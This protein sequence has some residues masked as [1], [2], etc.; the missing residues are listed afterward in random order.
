MKTP[1]QELIDEL[2]PFANEEDAI[3]KSMGG[4][5]ALAKILKKK[6]KVHIHTAFMMGKADAITN[7]YQN[8]Y[9]YYEE[10]YGKED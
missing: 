3:S 5:I 9:E 4:I 7:Q 10:L 8:P 1:I 2:K 6:E